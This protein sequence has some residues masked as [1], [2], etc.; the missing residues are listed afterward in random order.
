MKI[1]IGADKSGFS[2]KESLKTYLLEKGYE[3]EDLGLTDPDG[4]KAYYEVAPAVA[5]KVQ[6]GEAE[7][8][9]LC[10]GTGMG[11]AIVAN[12]FKGVY[13]SVVEGS[14]TL[15]IRLILRLWFSCSTWGAKCCRLNVQEA[16]NN[17]RNKRAGADLSLFM[18]HTAHGVFR[19]CNIS[20]GDA[21]LP[22]PH[23]CAW[24]NGLANRLYASTWPPTGARLGRLA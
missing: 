5:K 21:V 3:V 1:A 11:M 17:E 10:C 13:A 22:D 20:Q 2:L 8:G 18:V 6:S 12:K 19:P 16:T 24:P 23:S 4:F 7:K 9:I 15:A 14:F